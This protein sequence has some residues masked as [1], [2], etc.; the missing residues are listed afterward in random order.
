MATTVL[1]TFNLDTKKLILDDEEDYSGA[2]YPVGASAIGVNYTITSPSNTVIHNNTSTTD[3][4]CYPLD[5]TEFADT[6]LQTDAAGNVLQGVYSIVKNVYYV[7]GDGDV[8]EYW[9]TESFQVNLQFTAPTAE[10]TPLINYY[11]PLLSVTDDTN[12]TV[13]GVTYDAITRSLKIIPPG[14]LGSPITTAGGYVSTATFY[15]Q[16]GGLQYAF[17]LDSTLTYLF[18]GSG[19]Y[20]RYGVVVTIED[21]EYRDIEVPDYICKVYCVLA[22]LEKRYRDVISCNERLQSG[23]RTKFL[24]ASALAQLMRQA[25]LCGQTS[26][27]TKFKDAILSLGNANDDCCCGED[28]GPQLV[29][30][31]GGGA[32]TTIVQGVAEETIVTFDGSDTYTVGLAPEIIEILNSLAYD[33]TSEDGTVSVTTSTEDGVTTYDLSVSSGVTAS[34]LDV[35][36]SC[37]FPSVITP[38][39]AITNQSLTGTIFQE[40]TQTAPN[41][42]ISLN[43]ASN[44]T[45][46]LN[47]ELILKLENFIAGDPLDFFVS[48]Q[49]VV[50]VK[51]DAELTNI[52]VSPEII[53]HDDS[54]V[55]IRIRHA[56]GTMITGAWAGENFK[57]PYMLKITFTS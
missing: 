20:E 7:D 13:N 22:A 24:V 14:D 10:A 28:G 39:F 54:T 1:S 23:P 55:T 21:D 3:L 6:N 37:T 36:V 43:T 33:V 12:Y 44:L 4:D 26:D 9:K 52:P 47:G 30:G 19:V 40:V 56:D 48:C 50:S 57:A 18:E 2:V 31:I 15:G 53:D 35:E 27:V 38:I 29:V 25:Y 51:S 17:T 41:T 42:F 16:D 11:S 34:R 32:G 46:Y 49:S 45:E 8:V 5:D